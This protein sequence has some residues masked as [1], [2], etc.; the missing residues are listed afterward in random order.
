[1]LA[2]PFSWVYHF[3]LVLL[4]LAYLWAK[5]RDATGGEIVTLMAATLVLATEL[6]MDI[7]VYSPWGGHG[8]IIAAIALWPAPTVAILGVGMRMYVRSQEFAQLPDA[9]HA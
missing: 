7:A 3:V 6:P 5:A 4:P 9:A 1:M 8:P 2:A